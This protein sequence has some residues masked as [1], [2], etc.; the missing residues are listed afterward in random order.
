[1]KYNKLKWISAITLILLVAVT[2]IANYTVESAT[3]SQVYNNVSAI[4]ANRVG[5]L[6]GTSRLLSNGRP[7]QYF[8]YRIDAVVR[9][10][11]TR[12]I[13]YVV[14]SGDNSKK[15]YNEPQDMKEALMARGLPESR[16]YLD[17]AGFRTYDSVYRMQ[18]IFGQ[19]DFTI[20]SQEFHNKRA[21]YIAQTLKLHAVGFNARNVTKYYGFK[22][23]VREK[24]SRVKMFIDL[25]LSKKPRFLG[26]KVEIK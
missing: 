2:L 4:P 19:T 15:S 26:D 14:I 25:A 22:T 1:M 6:L 24:F 9:L 18:A 23:N 12:K 20:I 11:N 17:Y 13:K 8:T 16:I 10:I 21:L 3:E 7:N 5:L